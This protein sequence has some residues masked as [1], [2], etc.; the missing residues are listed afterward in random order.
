MSPLTERSIYWLPGPAIGMAL[1]GF[2]FLGH[3]G[4]GLLY[5]CMVGAAA[6]VFLSPLIQL[7]LLATSRFKGRYR[8]TCRVAIMTVFAGLCVPTFLGVFSFW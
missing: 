8:E 3:A 1:L 5:L 2:A 6:F 7:A 4:P